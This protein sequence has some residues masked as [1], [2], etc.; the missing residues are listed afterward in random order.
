M[1]E[2]IPLDARIPLA[3]A[4][5]PAFLERVRKFAVEYETDEDPDYL[6]G[7][8]RRCFAVDEYARRG[9]AILNDGRLVGHVLLMLEEHVGQRWLTIQQYEL[10]KGSG[11]TRN[12]IDFWMEAFRKLGRELKAKALRARVK[13]EVRLRAFKRYGFKP[14]ATILA[15]DL[16]G[17]DNGRDN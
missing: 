10:D 5:M 14:F 16:T 3:W 8:V 7:E 13:D 11:V 12:V 2:V 15:Q 9:V 4:L 1:V 6:C 17:V